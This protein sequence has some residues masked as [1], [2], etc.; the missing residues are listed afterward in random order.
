MI[1]KVI[2]CFVIFGMV[3]WTVLAAIEAKNTIKP[4]RHLKKRR[5]Y[6]YH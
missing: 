2:F 1:F 5:D 4:K 6:W 3:I